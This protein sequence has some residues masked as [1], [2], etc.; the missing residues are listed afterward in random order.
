MIGKVI[1]CFQ[2]ANSKA[3]EF[4]NDLSSFVLDASADNIFGNEALILVM[5]CKR[6]ILT[7]SL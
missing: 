6:V 5:Y 1:C 2:G 7:C 3:L 4:K